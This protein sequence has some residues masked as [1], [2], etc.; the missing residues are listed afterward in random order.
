MNNEARAFADESR[1]GFDCIVAFERT[2]VLECGKHEFTYH[3]KAS[4]GFTKM[5]REGSGL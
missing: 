2:K 4:R 3:S 1:T 5:R